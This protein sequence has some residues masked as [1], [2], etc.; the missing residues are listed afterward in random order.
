MSDFLENREMRVIIRDKKSPWSIV[1]SGVP[2]ESV[3]ASIMFAIYIYVIDEGVCCCMN[4]FTDVA[5][6]L[7]KIQN[8]NSAKLQQELDKIWD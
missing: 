5:K 8:E 1:R 7:A 3:L 2:Q 4:L 6:L